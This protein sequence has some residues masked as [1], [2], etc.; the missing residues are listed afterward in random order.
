MTG[1]E[2]ASTATVQPGHSSVLAPVDAWMDHLMD[3]EQDRLIELLA[4]QRG[5]AALGLCTAT[6]R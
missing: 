5:A 4:D 6:I 2:A 3:K 1:K